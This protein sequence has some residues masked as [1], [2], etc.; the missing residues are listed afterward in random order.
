MS[1]P[2]TLPTNVE[3]AV[4]YLLMQLPDEHRAILTAMTRQELIGL[5]HGYG[6]GIRNGLGLWGQNRALMNDPELKGMAPDDMSMILI[7]KAWELLQETSK[8]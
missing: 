2:K 6:S 7:E 1:Y 4:H 8:G 3:D 5:H